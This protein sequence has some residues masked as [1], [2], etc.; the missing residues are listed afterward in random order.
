[1]LNLS[2][3][4][5]SDLICKSLTGLRVKDFHQLVLIFDQTLVSHFSSPSRQRKF[6][7]GRKGRLMDSKKKLFF[8]LFYMKCYPTYDL[9][10]FLWEVHRSRPQKWFQRYKGVLE[11]ALDRS[12]VLP[13]R[14]LHSVEEFLQRFPE[15]K[16]VMIDSTERKIRR[17][18]HAKARKKQYSG[19]Q[20]AHTR[21]NTVMVDEKLRVLLVSPTKQGRLH[22]KKQADKC[23][24]FHFLPP[25]V[26]TWVDTG[27]QGAQKLHPQVMIPKKRSKGQPPLS[28]PE[29][30][31]NA[32][33]AG[34]RIVVEHAIAGIKRM[35]CLGLFRNHRKNGWDEDFFLLYA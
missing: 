26:T 25:E 17:P 2:R 21:K 8:L 31:E 4:L 14:K 22:D 27:F 34:I 30:A 23:C 33:I 28:L 18:S 10:G 6:G 29:K 11:K 20:K 9:A 12:L 19:K 15:V 24:F 32:T 3:A 13:E 1:M 7:G 35:S 16:D 5:L